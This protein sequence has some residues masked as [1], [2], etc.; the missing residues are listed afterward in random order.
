[1]ANASKNKGS[2]WERQL[3]EQLKETFNG[4]FQRVPNSG[5]F[6]GGLNFFRK[7]T[8]S[9][10]QQKLMKGD[11][12]PPDFM[13]KFVIECKFYADFG[14]HKMLR[15]ANIQLDTWINQTIESAN[16]EDFWILC[17]K[18][19]NKGSFVVFDDKH[20]NDFKFLN[21]FRYKNYVL[22]DLKIFLSDNK[23]KILELTK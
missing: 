11:I 10:N 4:N 2:G 1:M 3:C 17:I 9:A 20:L 15:E 5:A 19:N 14:F 6:T 23:D 8:M 18:L 22:T 12:I 16:A 21:H 13:E 7:E